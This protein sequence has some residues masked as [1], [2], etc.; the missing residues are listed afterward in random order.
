MVNQSSR[1][2]TDSLSPLLTMSQQGYR[3]LLDQS[4]IKRIWLTAKR[5]RQLIQDYQLRPYEG[6]ITLFCASESAPEDG[7]QRWQAFTSHPV[8]TVW[9]SGEHQNMLHVEHVQT[10]GRELEKRLQ[11]AVTSDQ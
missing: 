11:Q 6:I 9:V 2:G 10:L 5:N 1:F 8:D 7:T 3:H 4:I